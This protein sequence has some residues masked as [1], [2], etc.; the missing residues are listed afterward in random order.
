MSCSYNFQK[1]S[2][3]T[4]FNTNIAQTLEETMIGLP[5][6]YPTNSL[7]AAFGKQDS[8]GQGVLPGASGILL[9]EFR[10]WNMQLSAG[11][12]ANNRY[13]QVD[14]TK[15]DGETLIVYLR[16]ATGSSL[17]D[18]F[19]ARNDF[20]TFDGFNISEDGL[21]YVEDFIETEN[22]QYDKELD[23]VVSQKS[24][25]YHTVCPVHTY[26]MKQYCYSEPVNKAVL[27]VFPQWNESS[28]TLGWEMTLVHSSVINHE[29]IQFLTDSWSSTDS[30]LN[31][32]LEQSTTDLFH[33]VPSTILRHESE[34]QLQASLTNDELTFLKK[35]EIR[36]SPS[37]CK[38]FTVVEKGV[39][40]GYD[41]F[42]VSPGT[43]DIKIQLELKRHPDLDCSAFDFFNAFSGLD[44]DFLM[45]DT[46]DYISYIPEMQV[47][48][49]DP[50]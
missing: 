3:G 15:L 30:I 47:K 35:S 50:V 49:F 24:R 25:T 32:F 40:E 5:K 13:R 20:Y 22:Y 16:M 27:A 46:A 14:P 21:A 26:F 10:Y 29:V 45:T 1:S 17:I 37:K 9:K 41:I 33:Q 19:A 43:D 18:N 23:L 39:S 4:L 6:F 7:Y 38:W 31:D 2:K 42:Q 12:L 28:N 44:F 34:Y 48:V 36:F 11:E 8:N